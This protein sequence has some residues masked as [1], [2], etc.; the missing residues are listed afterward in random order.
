M[1]LYVLESATREILVTIDYYQQMPLKSPSEPIVI[2]Q[3]YIISL[4]TFDSFS[5]V[6][7]D[8]LNSVWAYLS[9]EAYAR[10]RRQKKHSE[11]FFGP[12][13]SH[14]KKS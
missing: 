4:S 13:A 2:V 6:F 5:R 12:G 7:D 3:K 14:G 1:S 8:N 10:L 9:E 11:L